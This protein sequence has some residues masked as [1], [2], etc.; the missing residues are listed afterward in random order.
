MFRNF[1]LPRWWF[2]AFSGFVIWLLLLA[3]L[4]QHWVFY[5]QQQQAVLQSE[6]LSAFIRYEIGRYADVAAE[7]AISASLQQQLAAGGS[8]S[9][10]SYLRDLQQASKTEDVYLLDLNGKV[11]AASNFQSPASYVGRD[12]SFRPYV[13]Q[14]LAGKPGHYYALGHT[15]GRRGYYFSAPVYE[16]Q[17]LKSQ[18][19]TI[20]AV[21]A[22][23]IDL[24][25][26]EHH[27]QNIAGLDGWHFLVTGQ[28]DEVFLSDRPDW[29]FKRLHNRP[30]SESEQ[31]RYL[32]KTLEPLGQKQQAALL[33]PAYTLWQLPSAQHN[34]HF[35]AYQ[36]PLPEFQWQLVLLQQ[37]SSAPIGR[38]LAIGTLLYLGFAFLLLWRRER[39]KRQQQLK[40]HNQALE[41]RVLDRT[42]EL[43][44]TNQRLLTQIAK[45][46]QTESALAQTEQELVQ[47]AK[48]ATIGSLSA[49][50]NHELNQPLTALQSYTQNTERML[51]KNM[52]ADAK[53][54]LAAMLKLIQ[55]LANIIAQFKD[56][57]RPGSGKN[58]SVALQT[59]LLDA[60]GI[61]QHQCQRQG[62]K[63]R[64]KQPDLPLLVLVDA[65]QLEQVLVNIL[66]NGLQAM[67]QSPEPGFFIVLE[68]ADNK[69]QIRIRDLG[70]GIEPHHLDKIFEAFF[71]TKARDGLGLGLSI[72]QRIVQSFG[73]SL[74]VANHPPQGAE[75]LIQLPLYQHQGVHHV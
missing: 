72:S 52:L 34:Q 35:F 31:Q 8:N 23:K 26:I 30:M 55:R 6:R 1:H 54:N 50:L 66:T 7:L 27:Q 15:S 68:Q 48:L 19:P 60:L 38:M 22:L 51:E 69:A 33:A 10:N 9:L 5:Q 39:S 56:F 44:E 25:P 4:S 37:P 20:K 63:T 75:F 73:G 28:S 74:T 71:S 13:Q 12:F 57:S 62:V 21:L 67:L 70:P 41:Q 59:V 43:A 29:R 18:P 65:I 14:A 61:V 64:L 46:E 45:R 47:A 32:T 17:R 58:Q 40:Q 49:S 53:M 16:Q 3:V 42:A 36:S 24:E 2:A 11:I